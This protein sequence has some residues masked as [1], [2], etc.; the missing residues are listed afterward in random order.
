MHLATLIGVKRA[1]SLPA[2]A[3][4]RVRT[5]SWILEKVLKFC[6]QFSR[7]GKTLKMEI[8]SEKMLKSFEFFFVDVFFKAT[9]ALQVNFFVF[10]KSYS[11]RAYFAAHHGKSFVPAFFKV[12]IDHPFNKFESG[13]RNF[14]F[15]KKNGKTLE[16]CVQKSLRTLIVNHESSVIRVSPLSTVIY[17]N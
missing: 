7:P 8:K 10:I 5:K 4:Y 17:Q 1:S 6:R 13:K 11:I 14:F 16:L 12:S 9:S 3:S 15:S 2:N